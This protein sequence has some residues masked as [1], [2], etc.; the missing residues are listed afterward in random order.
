MKKSLSP[1]VVV[2]I[3]AIAVIVVGLIVFKGTGAGGH[4]E[5]KPTEDLSAQLKAGTAPMPGIPNTAK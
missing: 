3:I 2:L 5:I 1:G 4:N